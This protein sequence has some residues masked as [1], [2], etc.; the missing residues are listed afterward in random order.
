MARG[1][2]LFLCSALAL[3]GCDGGGPTQPGLEVVS[4]GGETFHLELAADEASTTRGL[5]HRDA[6]P[7]DGGMLFVFPR[8]ELRTFWMGHCLIDIDII[9][10]DGRGRVTATHTMKAETP[11]AEGET[12][13]AYRARMPD[14][15]SR[16]PAQF[17]IEL[18]AGSLERLDV[19]FEDRI[20]LDLERLKAAANR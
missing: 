16:L 1:L 17:A 2:I 19:A 13:A 6:V 3:A 20:E 9:F 14:Y 18:K 5:M 4:I 11:Q 8:A 10:L 12:D 15:S 7:D